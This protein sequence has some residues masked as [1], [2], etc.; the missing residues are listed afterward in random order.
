MKYRKLDTL[1]LA[2][3]LLLGLLLIFVTGSH[4]KNKS[5]A[6][7]AFAPTKSASVTNKMIYYGLPMRL[8]IP[9]IGIDTSIES[10]GLTPQG[11][12]DAPAGPDNVGWY[13]YGAIPGDSG[14]AVLD[15][16]VVGPR[17][18][19]GVL[20]NLHKLQ[21][22]DTISVID[23]KSQ[24][25]SFTVREIRSYNQGEQHSEVF[26][27]QDKPH[28]NIITCS[29]DWSP[30]QHHYLERLVVFTDLIN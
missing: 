2:S 7:A 25:I 19:E 21:V 24:I 15:G 20:F 11:D 13:K 23:G 29:G 17:G 27:A 26:S 12:M 6:P 5:V 9:A 30:S 14:S 22:G 1:V 8:K 10:L 18:E 28:L 4:P 3:F 16:H